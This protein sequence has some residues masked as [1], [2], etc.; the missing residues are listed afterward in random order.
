[1][2]ILLGTVMEPKKIQDTIAKELAVLT[3]KH[4]DVSRTY[5]HTVRI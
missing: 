2:V 5:G 3:I 4:G 1:M